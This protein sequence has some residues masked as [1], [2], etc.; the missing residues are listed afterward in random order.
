[1]AEP[2]LRRLFDETLAVSPRWLDRENAARVPAQ[3]GRTLTLDFEFHDMLAGWPALRDGTSRP[4]RL[5]LKQARTLE[6]GPRTVALDAQAWPLP[7]DVFVRAR[8]V[9]RE[10]CAGTID[11]TQLRA[12]VLRA[13]T[14][15]SLPP[16]VG[17]S[18][19]PMD[20]SVTVTTQGPALMAL[21]WAAGASFD[22]N[23][24]E[25]TATRANGTLTVVPS[26][27]APARR[28]FDRVTLGA[29][30]AIELSLGAARARGT[31]TCT[32][33]TLFASP[34]DYL[35]SLVGRGAP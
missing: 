30:G 28:G 5:V 14:D 13:Q 21:G 31:L 27:S 7:R 8:R 3:R 19:T 35:L 12:D 9:T 32:T 29:D 34:R 16:D 24:S 23:H 2:A 22:V 15:T 33:E 10:R 11:G 25:W 1:L 4:A 20:A 6:P 26:E 17:F 18:M